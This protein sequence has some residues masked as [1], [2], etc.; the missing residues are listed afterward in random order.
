MMTT[1]D[2]QSTAVARALRDDAEW[3][4]IHPDRN[5]RAREALPGEI[6]ATFGPLV[7][8]GTGVE[9]VVVRQLIPGVR[10][11]LPFISPTP[12]PDHEAGLEIMYELIER[13]ITP[14]GARIAA[15]LSHRYDLSWPGLTEGNSHAS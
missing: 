10:S 7:F 9:R 12:P 14:T 5:Y 6:W 11:R 4:T 1:F 15:I 8:A 3:F 13:G 2:T